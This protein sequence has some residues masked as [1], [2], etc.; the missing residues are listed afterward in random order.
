M[1]NPS[2]AILSRMIR[3]QP[4][5]P[6]GDG[7]GI[8]PDPSPAAALRTKSRPCERPS[9]PANKTYGAD[10]TIAV[11][12]LRALIEATSSQA[13]IFGVDCPS[14]CRVSNPMAC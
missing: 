11:R 12:L 1:S 14:H 4:C 5:R 10:K 13:E 6:G 9:R 8:A 7:K 3:L 2:V